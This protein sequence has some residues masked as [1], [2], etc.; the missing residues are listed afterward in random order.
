[1]GDRMRQPISCSF[2]LAVLEVCLVDGRV[3]CSFTVPKGLFP[4]F[5]TSPMP[6]R[7]QQKEAVSEK[8]CIF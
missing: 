3:A 2:G 5:G 6:P 4:V 1:M 8:L 7:S